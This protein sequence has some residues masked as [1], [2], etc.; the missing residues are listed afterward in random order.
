MAGFQVGSVDTLLTVLAEAHTL[1]FLGNGSLQDQVDHGQAFAVLAPGPPDHAVDLGSGGGLPGLVLAQSWPSSSWIL[2]DANQR[3]T[4]F[5]RWAVETLGWS[6]R[7][8]VRRQRAEDAGRDPLLRAAADLVVARSFGPPAVTAECAAPLLRSG[9]HL[10][11]AEPPGGDPR[12]W[13]AQPLA[14]LGLRPDRA[15]VKPWAVQRLV[16]VEP[17]PDRY[18]R[19]SGIPAKRPL[20]MVAALAIVCAF[21]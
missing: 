19:R 5:L 6:D 11:V 2:L 10:L 12:R 16:Q 15:I 7:V 14:K 13:P 18:P 17:C 21:P 20:Y 3:R 4:E 8:K 9:G 1:G